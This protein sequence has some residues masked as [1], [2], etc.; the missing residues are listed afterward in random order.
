MG[1]ILFLLEAVQTVCDTLLGVYQFIVIG[2]ALVSWVNPDPYNP[3][4]RLLRNLT[5]PLLWRIRKYLPFTYKSGLDFSPLV[6]L[7]AVQII[8]MAVFRICRQLLFTLGT[9]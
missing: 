3:L 8:K 4:V 9:A 6:L 7:L 5:E 1:L 2:A